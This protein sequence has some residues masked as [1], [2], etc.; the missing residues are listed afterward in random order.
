MQS[1]SVTRALRILDLI[2]RAENPVV[3][4]HIAQT[5]GIPKSTAHGILRDLARERFVDVHEPT[6]YTV[7]IKAFEVGAA[8]L[9]VAGVDTVIAS[10][11]AG[12]T[13]ALEVT[14]HYAVLDGVEAVYLYKQDPPRSGVQLASSVGARLPAHLTAVG[15]CG[16]AWLEP[17]QVAVH[18]EPVAWAEGR[19]AL[20]REL[21]GIR[22]RGYADDH[23]QVASGV[24]CVAAPVFDA[25]G[26]RGAVGVSY[27]SGS[28]TPGP[29][30]TE[31][32]RH[33]AARLTSILGGSNT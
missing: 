9:R 30:L 32:V 12:L 2:A 28:P 21:A 14:A 7:G 4:K 25:G 5:L 23:G 24:D 18:V 1:S 26:P 15:K 6:A 19:E 29:Q 31:Q 3:L 13:R 16:L 33:A 11:L 17:A 8:H 22:E 20:V 27:L 10:E